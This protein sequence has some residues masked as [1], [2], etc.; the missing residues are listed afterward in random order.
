MLGTGR[1]ALRERYPEVVIFEL[2]HGGF[3]HRLRV[4][5]DVL[6]NAPL[7]YVRDHYLAPFAKRVIKKSQSA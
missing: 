1:D 6:Q 3:T 4:P 5:E 2:Q 7:D